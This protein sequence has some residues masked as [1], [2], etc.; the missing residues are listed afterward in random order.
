MQAG[1]RPGATGEA[2]W[3]AVA[4]HLMTIF[5]YLPADAV[6]AAVS[7]AAREL[8]GQVAPGAKA[9]MVHRLAHCRLRGLHTGE[10]RPADDGRQ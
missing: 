8:D 7:Q 10:H 6:Q 3:A 9:E 5:R 1:E 2:D 4:A